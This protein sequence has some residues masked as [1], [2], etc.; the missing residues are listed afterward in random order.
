MAICPDSNCPGASNRGICT[1]IDEFDKFVSL[2]FS[3]DQWSDDSIDVAVSIVEDFTSEDW[4]SLYE[5]LGRRDVAWREKLA[6]CLGRVRSEESLRCLC[7]L[8]DTSDP[9][10]FVASADSRREFDFLDSSRLDVEQL[11]RRC[12][13]FELK[14]SIEDIVVSDFFRRL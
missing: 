13:I 2:D 7:L 3:A 4:C 8:L 11:M 1:F 10:V 9:E 6:Q 12:A 14:D 5:V